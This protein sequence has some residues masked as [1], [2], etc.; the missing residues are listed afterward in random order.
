MPGWLQVLLFFSW[1]A[2]AM[3]D[4]WITVASMSNEDPPSDRNTC[5]GL[6]RPPSAREK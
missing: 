2:I 3:L 6:S 4:D 5:K 1:R